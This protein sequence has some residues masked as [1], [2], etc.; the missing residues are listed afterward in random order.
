MSI[1]LHTYFFLALRWLQFLYTAGPLA[2]TLRVLA[3]RRSSS[4][5]K[6][7]AARS[8]PMSDALATQLLSLRVRYLTVF[9]A[10]K[11]ADW[12]QVLGARG[13]VLLAFR[14]RISL[15]LSSPPLLWATLRRRLQACSRV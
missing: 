15:L 1:S 12:L 14:F 4:A 13:D 7:D 9:L 10:V 6:A 3:N 2:L 11:F 5:T 8:A